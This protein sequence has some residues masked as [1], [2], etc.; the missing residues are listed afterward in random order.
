MPTNDR[1]EP[2]SHPPL[3]VPHLRRRHWLQWGAGTA[4]AA[5]LPAAAQSPQSGA[6]AAPPTIIQ[7]ADLSRAQQ[8]VSR[9]FLVGSRTAWQE[10]NARGGLRGRPVR[11]Q[12]I[13][14]DGTP[15]SLRNAWQAAN[16]DAT[17]VALCGCV[18]NSVAQGLLELQRD[19]PP[20]ERAATLAQVAPWLQYSAAD[21]GD[22]TFP[23]FAGRQAQIAYAIRTLSV[24]G[25][26]E[27]GVIYA[28]AQTQA[29]ARAEI[30]Q[31]TA[32]LGLKTQEFV[33]AAGGS[34][35]TLGRDLPSTAPAMLLF[36]GG[37]PEMIELIRG[38]RAQNLWRYLVALADVNLQVLAQSGIAAR[39]V[40]VIAT[41]AVPMLTAGVPVVRRYRAA[42]AL[43][44][45]EP[46][47]TLGLAG[48]IAA[49]YAAQVLAGLDAAPTRATALAAFQR[50]A[51]M[52]L[53][54]FVIDYAGGQRS[55]TGVTQGML[56]TDGRIVG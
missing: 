25:V 38:L 6:A 53:G 17:C 51:T 55:A 13:E 50:R 4:A 23:I 52:D 47:S 10:L 5:L 45:D 7:I 29:D 16:E 9:D 27:L 30:A 12:V 2:F 18:G 43:L 11:H 49:R 15:A 48:Y 3:P 56:A 19:K 21:V 36:V 39:G 34:L 22:T 31:A 35:A 33:P 40:S 41:Q 24:V 37:T 44:F 32:S 42:L 8:D 54:G 1:Q 26:S 46:P 14:I 28:D 20:G